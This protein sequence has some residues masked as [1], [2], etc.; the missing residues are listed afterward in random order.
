MEACKI[1]YN[2]TIFSITELAKPQACCKP[3]AWFLVLPSDLKWLNVPAQLKIKAADILFPGQVTIH[4][5]VYEIT[6]CIARHIPNP[7]PLSCIADYNHLVENTLYQK[8]P[9]VKVIIKAIAHP[10]VQHQFYIHIYPVQ[11]LIIL[12]SC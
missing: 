4:D 7:L 2:L 3:A 11:Y 9:M 10:Q 5:D 1:T 8:Q 6:F 12:W